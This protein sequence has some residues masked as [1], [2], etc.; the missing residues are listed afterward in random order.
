[1]ADTRGHG[2]SYSGYGMQQQTQPPVQP[3]AGSGGYSSYGGQSQGYEQ[4]SNYQSGSYGQPPANTYGGQASTYGSQPSA[5][6]S[7]LQPQGNYGGPPPQGNY[8]GPPSGGSYGGPQGPNYGAPPPPSN[9][10]YGGQGGGFNSGL[11]MAPP[12]QSAPPG[13]GGMHGHPKNQ[14]SAPTHRRWQW[15]LRGEPV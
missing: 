7:A 1:M 5:S 13:F 14:P 6:Y 11:G 10:N 2:S 8:G 15:E 4:N 12:P 3:A 9:G